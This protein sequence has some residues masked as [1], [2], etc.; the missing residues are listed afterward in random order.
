MS[1]QVIQVDERPPLRKALP[2]SLQHLFAMFGSTV[3][4]PFL[5]GLNPGIALLT[6]GIGTL[7]YIFLT[8]GKIPGY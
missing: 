8:K 5:T 6:S 3:L 4:V 2:L 1:Q 7:I